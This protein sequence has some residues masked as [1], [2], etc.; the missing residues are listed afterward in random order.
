MNIYK[1]SKKIHS[2]S[3]S[4]LFPSVPRLFRND[5]VS[6][7]EPSEFINRKYIDDLSLPKTLFVQTEDVIVSNTADE[8]SLVGAGVG[9]VTLPADFLTAG[10]TLICKLHGRLSGANALAVTIKIK[11][12]ETTLITCTG[13]LS[14]ALD[15][16]PFEAELFLT[17][18]T[19]GETGTIFAQGST[20]IYSAP[21]IG[22]TCGRALAMDAPVVVDTTLEQDIDVTYQ[23][24]AAA[25]TNNIKV[26][27][28]TIGAIN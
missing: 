18:R 6:G 2:L 22:T 25:E 10:K 27:D 14:E 3:L 19:I 7:F 23:F 24:G 26:S 1:F 21:G 15:N 8:T 11:I 12:G 4:D 5:T 20:T 17:C 13:N 9:S 28:L 16:V